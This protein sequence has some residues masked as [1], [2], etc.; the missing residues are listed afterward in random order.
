MVVKRAG[1]INSTHFRPLNFDRIG[2]LRMVIVRREKT[3]EYNS[4]K[5][6]QQIQ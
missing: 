2:I 1:S 4:E 6:H 3:S 5:K